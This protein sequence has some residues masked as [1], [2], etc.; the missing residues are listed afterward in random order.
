MCT[1][2]VSFDSDRNLAQ[3]KDAS[4]VAAGSVRR[5][6]MPPAAALAH[7][8]IKMLWFCPDCCSLGPPPWR[9][10]EATQPAASAGR[11]HAARRV[12]ERRSAMGRAHFGSPR[13]AAGWLAGRGWCLLVATGRHGRHR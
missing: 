3:T 9:R 13:P 1:D 5:R 11:P 8:A 4:L 10:A 7:L 2:D 6:R 12:C